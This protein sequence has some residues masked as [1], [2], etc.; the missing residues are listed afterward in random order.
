MIKYRLLLTLPVLFFGVAGLCGGAQAQES[1][2]DPSGYI[3]KYNPNFDGIGPKVYFLPAPRTM[4]E[5]LTDTYNDIL[6]FQD[7]IQVALQQQKFK[8]NFKVTS[9][10]GS[11]Q[12]LLNPMPVTDEAWDA[13]IRRYVDHNNLEIA[14]GLLNE[15][16]RQAT[17]AG[18]ISWSIA[19]LERARDYV[20]LRP[21]P[22]DMAIIQ[23]NLATLQFLDLNATEALKYEEAYYTQASKDKDPVEQGQSLVKLAQIQALAEDYA[24]AENTIIRKAIPLFNRARFYEGKVW[25]WEMLADIYQAQN[26]HVQA[27][28][29]LIQARDLARAKKQDGE[30][31]E[32]E[33][34]LGSSKF[35]QK[36]YEV[37]K[38]EF[39]QAYDLAD[40]E[41]NNLLK[42]AIVEKL[43]T[44]YLLQNNLE[45]AD[46]LLAEYWKLRTDLF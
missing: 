33:Y 20:S 27:Q 6:P 3:L 21:H 18:R 34:M 44:I 32:I 38:T 45:L 36:N 25:A 24:L 37:A 4:K 5:V 39:M 22:R 40:K 9:N 28:W 46:Q 23:A 26:K 7:S 13:L 10:N 35:V 31:A 2:I 43:G 8:A 16:A 17:E 11:I 29:F 30:L 15:Q 41:D 42:L 14:Y 1:A 12:L 19:L